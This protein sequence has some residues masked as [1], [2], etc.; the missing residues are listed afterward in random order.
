MI[1]LTA[2]ASV[3]TKDIILNMLL[4]K[5]PWEIKESP[6]KLNITYAVEYLAQDAELRDY[7]GWLIHDLGL[8]QEETTRTIIYCQTIKQ[9]AMLYAIFREL[10]GKH[11]FV[12]NEEDPRNV[13]VEMLHSC[14]PVANKENILQSFQLERGTIR[15]LIATIAFGMGVDCK[16]VHNI[17]HIGPPKNIEAYMQETGRAGRDGSPS[18]AYILYKGILLNHV[19]SDIKL[20]VKSDTCR[21]EALLNHFDSNSEKPVILHLCCDNCSKICQCGMDDCSVYAKYPACRT[22]LKP[23]NPVQVRQ[24]VPDKKQQVEEELKKY[25]KSLIIELKNTSSGG[26]V[27]T[28]TNV[29]FMLGFSDYQI[30]QVLDNLDKLLTMSSIIENVE[31]WDMRHARKIWSIVQDVFGDIQEATEDMPKTVDNDYYDEEFIDEYLDDWSHLIDDDVIFLMA[32][33]N[34]TFTET[35]DSFVQDELNVS[36][37]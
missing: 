27:K 34:L 17:I 35:D 22:E 5:K 29:K 37:H 26:K 1:A 7:F 24:I 25:R 20:Y 36:F 8:K 4:M 32:I 16:G 13:L 3:L 18:M 11:I 31:I 6:N 14:T 15:V 2:T 12:G 19:D 23:M 33:D 30:G 9:C 10:L 28:L 21:R